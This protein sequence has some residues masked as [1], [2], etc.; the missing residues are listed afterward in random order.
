MAK[1]AAAAKVPTVVSGVDVAKVKSDVLNEAASAVLSTAD[2]KAKRE[3]TASL[4]AALVIHY[5]TLPR[6]KLVKCTTCG[7]VASIELDRC[8][9]CGD[10]GAE[11]VP[12]I[13]TRA[14]TS[15]PPV[16]APTQALQMVE[17]AGIIEVVDNPTEAMLDCVT[18]HIVEMKSNLHSA[19]WRLGRQIQVV[20]KTELWK[21]R[22]AAGKPLYETFNQYTES[23][24][25]I[26]SNTAFNFMDIAAK[27]TEEQ[28]KKLGVTKLQYV[29]RA[30]E[31]E[32]AKLLE[33]AE[34]GSV[35]DVRKELQAIKQKTGMQKRSTGRKEMPVGVPG[36]AASVDATGK[37]KSE[38][39]VDGK[40]T[41]ALVEG[42]KKIALFKRPEKKT[43]ELVPA[44]KVAE[45]PIGRE[46][47]ENSV[48]RIYSVA[49]N[50]KG[51]LVLTIKTT[52]A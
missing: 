32:Q 21:M 5:G 29:I 9:F 49:L 17:R 40:L 28:A 47:M 44:K 6:E 51:E 37:P 46:E 36:R 16:V 7:G 52:R 41:I 35:R 8:P 1:K 48:V 23:E 39:R 33:S 30:P 14:S 38:E 3:D 18:Q 24:L 42:T 19:F 50:P 20:F 43:D 25:H 13:A 15:P 2:Y 4:I 22:T 27:F 26:P 10:D 31:A 34:K 11:P 45:E 12:P